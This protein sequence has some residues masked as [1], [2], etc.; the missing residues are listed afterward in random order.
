MLRDTAKPHEAWRSRSDRSGHRP[1]EAL[2]SR[3][4]PC[5]LRRLSCS[6]CSSFAMA[7][8]QTGELNWRLMLS[9]TWR[10]LPYEVSQDKA[11]LRVTLKWVYTKWSNYRR[12]SLPSFVILREKFA[13]ANLMYGLSRKAT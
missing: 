12:Q 5:R 3:L 7:G 13:E 2:Q 6:L 4:R 8:P 9:T 1:R 11:A 10:E